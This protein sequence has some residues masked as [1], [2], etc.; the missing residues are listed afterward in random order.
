[1]ILKS[2]LTPAG[3]LPCLPVCNTVS[4]KESRILMHIQ[5]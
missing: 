2:A 5:T 4:K 3:L 1:M